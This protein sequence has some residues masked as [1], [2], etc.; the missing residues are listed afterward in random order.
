MIICP[1]CKHKELEGAYYC[2]ECGSRLVLPDPLS[3]QALR[4]AST[5]QL[6][7]PF[8]V[9]PT[10]PLTNGL[11]GSELLI[12]LHIVEKG[13]VMH[14][15]GRTEYVLGRATEGQSQVPD[16]DLSPYEAYGQGVSR[17]HALLKIA[18]QR[19]Y[20][21]DLGSSNGTRVNGQKIAPQTDFPVSHGDVFALGKLKIQVL[22]R[23]AGS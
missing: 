7:S 13:H 3:T 5:N 20:I 1:N 12:S 21:V 9:M 16:V 14:L 10:G 19:C 15:S 17:T 4:R 6:S 23:R 11:E 2:A 22:I 18:R 8:L